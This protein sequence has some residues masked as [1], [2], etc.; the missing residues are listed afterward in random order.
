VSYVVKKMT[1]SKIEIMS[2]VGSNESL[3]AAIQAGAGSVYFGIGEMNMRSH[4][5]VN[6]SEKD[7]TEIVAL[8]RDHNVKSYLTL[9]TVVFD[10][11]L[12]EMRRIVNLAKD[13]GVDAIIAS[14]MAVLEYAKKQ[15]IELHA[16]TQ[17]N[18]SNIE[19]VRFFSQWC[20]VVVLAREL[21]LVQ[22]A[23]I[24]R[25]VIALN[26]CGPS[27]N[28]VRIEVFVHGAL[29]M[30]TSGKC[31]LSLHHHNKSANRGKCYQNCRRSYTVTE[32]ETG[33]Q[34]DIENEYIMSPRDL[35]TIGFLDK[36]LDAGVTVLKIEGRAR[37]PEYVK[38]TTQCY[39]EAVE[40]WQ[41]GTFSQE[42]AAEWKKRM[43]S[44]FNRGF[45][46][47]YYLGKTEGEWAEQYGSAATRHKEY[48]GFVTNYYSNLGVAEVL[49]ESGSIAP[50]DEILI[51]GPSSGIVET[52]VT[53][54]DG[55][56]ESINICEKGSKGSFA[57]PEKVRRNDKVYKWVNR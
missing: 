4:S 33:Y 35:C 9:N 8:C 46:G 25:Q 41:S 56:K 27:G 48:L 52:T 21:T 7:L 53:R 14:D 51:T 38:I 39:H 32:K 1:K 26:I 15:G 28:H 2:P 57:V 34:L 40:A 16:S 11:E 29:C 30:A 43:A 23:E 22:Q 47:G 49:V 20:D 18:I 13:C 55:V 5:A 12:E 42:K 6:F 50:G 10:H 3:M 19:A 37:A 24:C 44:V 17:L 54:I 45:W 36:I 31:Y